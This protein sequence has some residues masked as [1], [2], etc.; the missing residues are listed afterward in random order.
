V[1]MPLP[2]QISR[3][4]VI[5]AIDPGKDVD[6]FHP[7]NV[8]LLY[9]GYTNCF[10]PCTAR[11]CLDLIKF[12][13]IDPQEDL[14][15]KKVVIIGRSNIVGRPLAALLLRE[16]ATVT[17]CHSKT[18]NLASTTSRADIV[19]SAVGHP[20]FLTAEYFSAGATVIDVG[21]NRLGEN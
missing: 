1:Q 12:T 5:N 20:G 9:S 14:S 19:V 4:K 11:G 8:G 16:N 21:I 18:A 6:G 7:Y 13:Q 3:E 17:L 15:D 10:I 2:P